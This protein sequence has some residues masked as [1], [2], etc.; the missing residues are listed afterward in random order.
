MTSPRAA[1]RLLAILGDPVAHS[2]SPVIQNAAIRDTGVDGVYVALRCTDDTMPGLLTGIARAGGGG[3]VTVPHKRRA[4]ELVERRTEAVER[5]GACNTFWLEAG[6]VWGD[7]TDVLGFSAAVHALVGSP[8]GTRV[9]LLGAGG[10]ARA[11]LFSL[12]QEHVDS[13]VL[14]N[15][16]ADK[17]EEL[18]K[19]F[20]G[21]RGRVR[22]AKGPASLRREGFDLVV[23]ATSLGLHSEDASPIALDSLHRVGA[24][25]DMVYAPGGTSWTR[26]A[27]LLG[28]P[29]SDGTEMLLHQAGASFQR[30]WGKA[31]SLEAMRAALAE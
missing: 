8:A 1:T 3:N 7:N 28:I 18:R 31:A 22:V 30:W 16:T 6:E 10:A 13:V 29:A 25:L 4:C 20:G 12:L 2:L 17:V 14:L 27:K 9:L 5:T 11:A 26:E 23:N 21:P 15:R 24:A 19:T